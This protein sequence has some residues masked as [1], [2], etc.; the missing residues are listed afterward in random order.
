MNV[1]SVVDRQ[2]RFGFRDPERRY[3]EVSLDCDD[4]IPGRRRFRRTSTGWVLRMR[5]PDVGRLE[6]RLMLTARDGSVEVVCDPA[7]PERVRTAFGERS[8]ALLPGYAPPVWMH[9]D[10]PPGDTEY[11]EHHDSDIGTLPM[12]IWSPA[13]LA[14]GDTAP[15][16]VVHDGPEYVELSALTSYAAAMV[17]ARTLPPFRMAL[18]HP[19]KRDEWYAANPDYIRTE[20]A[21]LET[22]GAA[23]RISG[24]WVA[25]GASLGGLTALLLA[26][27]A[28][29]RFGGFLAQ[30]GSFFR[31]D[32][33]SQEEGY[34]SFARVVGAVRRIED[35]EPTGHRLQVAMTCGVLEE[36]YANN[37]EMFAALLR[38]GH[39]VRF[40]DVRDLHNYTAWRDSL[41]PALTELLRSVWGTQG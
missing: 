17:D 20:L 41:D 18:M 9:R 40:F 29:A 23:F 7:N 15:L 21:A 30:S 39:D 12:T 6:Y 14:G 22:V 31:A 10:V 8:V 3:A 24:P 32:L 11:L 27:A 35:A 16:L 1:P 34:P 26:L 36:N 2:L 33:D 37:L 4:A 28:P 38:L 19:V 25:M 5:A 13:G